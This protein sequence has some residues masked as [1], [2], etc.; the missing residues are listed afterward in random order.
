MYTLT[1]TNDGPVAG[2][3]STT[4]IVKPAAPASQA[5]GPGTI[6]PPV[7]LP[8]VVPPFGWPGGDGMFH[9]YVD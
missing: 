4:F 8:S 6:Q 3:A 9:G 2:S 5:F 7:E 1:V